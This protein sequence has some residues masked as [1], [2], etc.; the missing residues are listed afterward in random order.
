MKTRCGV[1]VLLALA[2]CAIPDRDNGSDPVNGRYPIAEIDVRVRGA[3]GVERESRLGS[4][5]STFVFD[6]AASYTPSGE[7]LSFA[8]EADD[9]NWDTGNPDDFSSAASAVFET[10]LALTGPMLEFSGFPDGVGTATRRIRLRITNDAAGLTTESFVDVVLEN[11]R[12]VVLDTTEDWF[13]AATN[14]PDEIVVDA[15]GLTGGT[16]CR[17]SDPDGD[18]LFFDWA[19]PA[20]GALTE[21]G[22]GR[23]ARVKL[24]VPADPRGYEMQFTVNDELASAAG[25][26]RIFVSSPLWFST[27]SPAL[28]HRVFPDYVAARA[29]RRESDLALEPF[30]QV[31]TV[32]TDGSEFWVS[33][34]ENVVLL[35]GDMTE[36]KRW[37]INN[38][39]SLAIGAEGSACAGGNVTGNYGVFALESSES[40]TSRVAQD[41]GLPN[42]SVA[43]RLDGTCWALTYADASTLNL[44]RVDPV[45]GSSTLIATGIEAPEVDSNGS[46]LLG[47]VLVT[48]TDGAAWFR[49][50]PGGSCPSLCRVAHDATSNADL[51]PITDADDVIAILPDVDGTSVLVFMTLGGEEFVQRADASGVLG[52]EVAGLPRVSFAYPMATDVAGRAVWISDVTGRLHRCIAMGANFGGCRSI[53]SDDVAG[54]ASLQWASLA[55]DGA[56]GAV[57]A[58]LVPYTLDGAGGSAVVASIPTHLRSIEVLPV[59]IAQGTEMHSLAADPATGSVFYADFNVVGGVGYQKVSSGGLVLDSSFELVAPTTTYRIEHVSAATDGSV[60]ASATDQFAQAHLVVHLDGNGAERERIPVNAPVSSLAATLDGDAVCIAGEGSSFESLPQVLTR[61]RADGTVESLGTWFDDDREILTAISRDGSC[62]FHGEISTVPTLLHF[63]AA[64]ASPSLTWTTGL[65]FGSFTRII[66]DPRDTSLWVAIAQPSESTFDRVFRLSA[67][68]SVMESY[69]FTTGTWETGVRDLAIREL[70]DEPE[71]ARCIEM[72]ALA[73]ETDSRIYRSD[74]RIDRPIHSFPYGGQPARLSMAP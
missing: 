43:S 9:P 65:A 71:N 20:E 31:T 36:R 58:A 1:G 38:V 7:P 15:C 63:P 16:S 29:F 4:R 32:T 48:A 21:I 40:V 24:P 12:P 51:V 6:G 23:T 73:T 42:P 22:N 74:G 70:C 61:R 30:T 14:T 28:L 57:R 19:E 26:I 68:G 50:G 18:Y 47:N 54:S 3:D 33:E 56:S 72:W 34:T 60:W 35:G 52:D 64:V 66:A 44:L 55:V 62:W 67:I 41:P 27:S 45:G 37:A 17:I 8:W 53:S 5:G 69:P 46:V 25:T 11:K 10:P 39:T 13:V 49:T 2:G 59:P